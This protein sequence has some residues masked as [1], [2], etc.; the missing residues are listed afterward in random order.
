MNRL[1]SPVTESQIAVAS[2]QKIL[3]TL[4]V[5]LFS[6]GLVSGVGAQ[7]PDSKTHAPTGLK[8][9]AFSTT[10]DPSVIPGVLLGDGLIAT[11]IKVQG[12]AD[13]AVFGP[14]LPAFG[15]FS[16]G[17]SGIGIDSG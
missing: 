15:S 12:S 6:V 7:T 14:S 13:Q 9:D 2:L 16:D 10:D 3:S 4:M 5:L 11:D 1:L 17:L 8:I